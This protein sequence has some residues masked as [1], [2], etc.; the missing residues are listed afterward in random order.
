MF[1]VLSLFRSNQ[2]LVSV[3]LIFYAGILHLSVWYIPDNWQPEGYGLFMDLLYQV[4]PPK[5]NIGHLLVIVLLFIQ[6]VTINMLDFSNK[7]SRELTLFPGV[8][9][10]LLASFYPSFLHLSPAHLANTFILFACYEIFK[11]YRK[12]KISDHLFNAGMF[13][14]VAFM[15]LPSVWVLLFFLF[16]TINVLRSYNLKERLITASGF[17]VIPFL[18]GTTYF[19]TDQWTILMA[20]PYF[21]DHLLD[22]RVSFSLLDWINIGVIGLLVLVAVFQHSQIM[23]KR[24]MQ[25][26]KKI[27]V[28][29]W[30]MVFAGITLFAQADFGAD[31][32]LLLVPPLGFLTGIQFATMDKRVAELLHLF[33]FL[34]AL[35]FQYQVLFIV[36]G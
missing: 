4:V 13:V 23:Q 25:A 33:L 10:V 34:L 18:V 24:I 31:H 27:D 28:F 9:L 22:S 36:P 35:F 32:I 29:Y 8:F 3:L 5:S 1:A 12:S 21:P 17:F 19:L 7:L 2:L 16:I 15:F 20:Y 11:V 26:Q 30:L 14:G 6:G